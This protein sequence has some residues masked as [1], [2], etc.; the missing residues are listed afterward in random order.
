VILAGGLSPDNVYEGAMAT[1]PF[2]VDSCTGTNAEDETARAIR[3]KKDY[4]KVRVFVAEARR[5][6]KDLSEGRVAPLRKEKT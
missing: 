1:N 2:G 4:E 6:A 3:F 5:A